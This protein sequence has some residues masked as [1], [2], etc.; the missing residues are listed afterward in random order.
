MSYADFFKRAILVAT[1]AII[2]ATVWYLKDTWL[3]VFFAS[4]LAVGISLPSGWLQRRFG[5][6][7]GVALAASIAGMGI[8]VYAMIILIFPPM[9]SELAG[10]LSGLPELVS[11]AVT[12]YEELR[13][14]SPSLERLLP[15][16]SDL[17][18][19]GFEID[20][21]LIDQL[22]TIARSLVSNG[23]PLALQGVG[24]LVTLTSN[25][26][27]VLLVS[28]FF[29]VE[30][31]SYITAI[32]YLIPQ[33]HHARAVEILNIL[34]QTLT[35]WL[36]AQFTSISITVLLVWVVL[37]VG[38]GMPN[39][40]T[41][42]IIAGLATFIPNVGAFLPLIPI[43]IFQL[44]DDPTRLLY[45]LPAYL[46]IQLIES[47]LLTPRIVG[48]ELNI[49]TGA[50]LIFQVVAAILFG[51]LGIILAV[52]LLAALIALAR[53]IYSYDFLGIGK[54]SVQIGW[55]DAGGLMLRE[56]E[57]LADDVS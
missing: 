29:L 24:A 34:Y 27:V 9:V 49:P 2:I 52:P 26:L 32:L 57:S 3:L 48:A 8:L 14:S 22:L 17:S 10:L 23:L 7:R 16:F 6:R 53:E 37:G 44:A 46:I 40:L 4:I 33:S 18:P 13:T 30:P 54:S 45:V 39:A 31:R 28:L 25:L 47:N 38:L 19:E 55:D 1:L 21:S 36:K 43:V 42:A 51:A 41:V 12:G 35:T 50:L 5:W 15:S 20:Q 56:G 11:D